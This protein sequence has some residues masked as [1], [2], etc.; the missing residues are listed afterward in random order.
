MS[1]VCHGQTACMVEMWAA[2]AL[3]VWALVSTAFLTTAR[4]ERKPSQQEQADMDEWLRKI[5]D[6]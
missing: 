4:D 5:R 2:I 3:I 6:R 1:E